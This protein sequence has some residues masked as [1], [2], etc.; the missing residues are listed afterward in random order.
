MLKVSHVTVLLVFLWTCSVS[1][2]VLTLKE[3]L[4]KAA[5][6]SP[7]PQGGGP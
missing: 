5:E 4:K 7:I 6:M 3:C 1:A 2:E